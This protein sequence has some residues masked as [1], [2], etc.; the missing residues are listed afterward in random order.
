MRQGLSM[1]DVK[2]CLDR[3]KEL[4]SK[5]DCWSCDCLQGFLVRLE[6]DSVED[7]TSLTSPL[8]VPTERMHGCLGCDPCPPGEAFAEYLRRQNAQTS[9]AMP[10]DE[11]TATLNGAKP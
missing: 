7:V 5:D 9:F 3:L 10:D 6:L 1:N 2:D 8:K 11:E 4:V